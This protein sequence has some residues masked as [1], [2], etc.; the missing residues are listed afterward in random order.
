MALRVLV[1][2]VLLAAMGEAFSE[3][4][5]LGPGLSY[6]FKRNGQNERHIGIGIE[7][8]LDERWRAVLDFRNNSNGDLSV[9]GAGCYMPGRML[10][11]R[12]GGCLGVA[13]G[14]DKGKDDD[15]EAE[16]AL[17]PLPFGGLAAAIERR[18]YGINVLVV[19]GTMVFVGVKFPR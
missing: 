11:W 9:Y 17:R 4:W 16:H 10:Q 12:T 1:A 19:P 3:D 13:T 8:H 2:V 15:R 5:W 14:Y 18:R 6:H 7:R